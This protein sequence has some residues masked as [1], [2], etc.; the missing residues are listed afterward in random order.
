MQWGNICLD[1]LFNFTDLISLRQRNLF[2]FNVFIDS[3]KINLIFV[4][5]AHLLTMSYSVCVCVCVSQGES[6]FKGM[7]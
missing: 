2:S 5:N 7:R 6:Y 1:F 4:F 3:P